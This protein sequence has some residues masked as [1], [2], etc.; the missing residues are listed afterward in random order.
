[1]TPYSP[2]AAGILLRHLKLAVRTNAEVQDLYSRPLATP[3]REVHATTSD[4]A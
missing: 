2:T 1:M 4:E 3:V